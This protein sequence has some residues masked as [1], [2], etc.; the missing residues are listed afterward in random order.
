SMVNSF[1]L[2]EREFNDLLLKEDIYNKA[3]AEKEILNGKIT[4]LTESVTQTMLKQSESSNKLNSIDNTIEKLKQY[5][6]DEVKK[7][8][9][10]SDLIKVK[11]DLEQ[12]EKQYL[13]SLNIL[14]DK[15]K[16]FDLQD[17]V[18]YSD[19]VVEG[20]PCPLCGSVDHPKIIHKSDDYISESEL[21]ALRSNSQKLS[22]EFAKLQSRSEVFNKDLVTKVEM[23]EEKRSHFEDDPSNEMLN[24]FDL[25]KKHLEG[26]L[27]V[28]KDSLKAFS[29]QKKTLEQERQK[30]IDT[31][32]SFESLK[33][34]FKETQ[35]KFTS[36]QALIKAQK[37]EMEGID[38]EALKEDIK[39]YKT[40]IDKIKSEIKSAEES[41]RNNK[42]KHDSLE[43]LIIN[44]SGNIN[45]LQDKLEASKMRLDNELKI[46]QIDEEEFKSLLKELNKEDV[47]LKESEAYF[48][49]LKEQKSLVGF[50]KKD[51]E[52][53]ELVDIAV[54]NEAVEK[55]AENNKALTIKQK[56]LNKEITLLESALDRVKNARNIYESLEGKVK[57]AKQFWDLASKG[58]NFENFVLSY[59]LDGVLNNANS[60]LLKISQGRFRL[61]RKVD[62]KMD[63]RKSQGLELNVFDLYT[64]S[65]RDVKTLSGGEGFKASLALALGLSDFIRESRTGMKIDYIFID[66]GFGT[67]D[68]DSLRDAL[69]MIMELNSNGRLVG[70]ISHVEELK[71]VITNKFIVESHGANGST[72]KYSGSSVEH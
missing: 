31:I 10:E 17:L 53:L 69:D 35:E 26:S 40:S 1:T 29:Q 38:P 70:I 43:S 54:L 58:V 51:S 37:E 20:A 36:N 34:K 39:N 32:N 72:V 42:S 65:E 45:K 62:P 2:L 44:T 67:L 24:S 68:Q 13:A 56:D 22:N 23:L 52:G 14:D 21:L 28:L 8:K 57:T 55:L 27:E 50:L 59:Y 49:K 18:K 16:L 6:D 15:Q 48:N 19:K 60:R 33:P 11:A 3:L 12:T 46:V 71:D 7:D 61:T 47:L 63:R 5:L 30:T 9:L 4:N 64:N 41:I 66:E 25:E